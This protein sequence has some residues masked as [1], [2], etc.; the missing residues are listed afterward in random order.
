MMIATA[1]AVAFV[2]YSCKGK[3]KEAKKLNIAETPVQ[4]VD[5]MFVAQTKNG[6]LQMRVEAKRMERFDNDSCSYEMFP[7]GLA[8]YGYTAD[9][10]LETTIFSDNAK[11]IKFKHKDEEYWA[12]F[13][14]VKVTNVIKQELM[15]SDTVYWDQAKHEI[16]TDCYVRMTSP[17]GFMQGYGMRSD[18]RAENAVIQKPFNSYGVVVEDTTTVVI[19]SANFIGPLLKK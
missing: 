5:G 9:G 2:V 19:D 14:N 3:L 17:D 6:D 10:L 18:E 13:G 16:Y 8:V 7:R 11:H 12:A 15:E 4:T 1:I